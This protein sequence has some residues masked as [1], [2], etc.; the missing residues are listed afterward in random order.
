MGHCSEK[1]GFHFR[2]IVHARRDAVREHVHQILRIRSIGG[3]DQFDQLG[4]LLGVQGQGRNAQCG[5]FGDMA[6]VCV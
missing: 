1:R 6:A 5:A 3:F 2:G 4:G